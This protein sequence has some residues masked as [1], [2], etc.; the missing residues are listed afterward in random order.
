MLRSMNE[1]LG[2]GVAEKDG[3]IGVVR[4][5]LFNQHG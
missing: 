1:L 2:Y 3:R 5:I 4:D